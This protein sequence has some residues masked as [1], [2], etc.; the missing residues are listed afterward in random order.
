MA[1]NMNEI[2]KRATLNEGKKVSLS[3]AQMKEAAKCILTELAGEEI[4]DV[5]K[6]VKRYRKAYLKKYASDDCFDKVKCDPKCRK[7]KR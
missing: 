3:I 6:V 4:I 1:I 2:I 7:G 5:I